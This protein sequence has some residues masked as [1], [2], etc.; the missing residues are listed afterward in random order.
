MSRNKPLKNHIIKKISSKV[1]VNAEATEP[2]RTVEKL[3]KAR[4]IATVLQEKQTS[5]T[6]LK[7]SL[8]G[9]DQ[10]LIAFRNITGNK[11]PVYFN[12]LSSDRTLGVAA[13]H[14]APHAFV[15]KLPNSMARV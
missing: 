11:T 10:K 6:E 4:K 7:G 15:G 12:I 8:I 2:S 14:Q 5:G 13:S 9:Q 3:E 1:S